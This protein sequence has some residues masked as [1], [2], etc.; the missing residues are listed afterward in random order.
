MTSSMASRFNP[1]AMSTSYAC[2]VQSCP[3]SKRRNLTRCSWGRGDDHG[4]AASVDEGFH[5]ADLDSQMPLGAVLV[6]RIMNLTYG[7]IPALRFCGCPIQTEDIEG[8]VAELWSPSTACLQRT[9]CVGPTE[10][11][12]IVAGPSLLQS[13]DQARLLAAVA[14]MLS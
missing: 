5:E 3:R 8:R 10:R 11:L 9:Y 4:V 2:W 13:P 6:A 1:N 12:W 7:G 14:H